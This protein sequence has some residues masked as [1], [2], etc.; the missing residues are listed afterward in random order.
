MI[1]IPEGCGCT[2]CAAA[3]SHLDAADSGTGAVARIEAGFECCVH[4]YDLLVQ[5]T[6]PAPPVEPPEPPALC[7]DCKTPVEKNSGAIVIGTDN[8]PYF[9]HDSCYSNLQGRTP[10]APDRKPD[11]GAV[12]VPGPVPE[13]VFPPQVTPQPYPL[14]AT[15]TNAGVTASHCLVLA[16]QHHPDPAQT[17]ILVGGCNGPEWVTPAQWE[18][19]KFET[20][21][22]VGIRIEGTGR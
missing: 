3:L 20:D 10:G 21:S 18:K 17:R 9:Y 15:F 5:H 12:P 2:K 4:L 19:T 1:T 16:W 22:T 6:H 14:W 7:A 13:L 8:E 11:P